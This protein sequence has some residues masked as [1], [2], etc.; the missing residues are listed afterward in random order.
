MYFGCHKIFQLQ[1]V[2]IKVLFRSQSDVLHS[3]RYALCAFHLIATGILGLLRK[4]SG[5]IQTE[6]QTNTTLSVVLSNLPFTA[7]T[8]TRPSKRYDLKNHRKKRS[9]IHVYE[10]VERILGRVNFG[11]VCRNMEN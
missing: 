8:G 5:R 6:A 11:R 10:D 4:C 9:E 7:E 1:N 3:S 2:A